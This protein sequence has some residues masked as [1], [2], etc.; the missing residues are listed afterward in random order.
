MTIVIEPTF[1]IIIGLIFGAVGGFLNSIIGWLSG[2]EPFSTRKNVKSIIVGLIAGIGVAYGSFVALGEA[3]T[4][5]A[6]F[7]ILVLILL[8]ASGVQQ[9]AH[10]AIK[11]ATKTESGSEAPITPPA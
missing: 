11:A 6:L 9:L 1:S 4:S 3:Q 7:G 5:Q 2:E 10:N 8:S